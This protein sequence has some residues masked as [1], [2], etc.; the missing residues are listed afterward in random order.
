MAT[1]LL[2][3]ADLL[4]RDWMQD[5]LADAGYVVVALGD[6][7]AALAAVRAAPPD[8]AIIHTEPREN[9]GARLLPHLPQEFPGLRVIAVSSSP[10]HVAH[11]RELGA[12]QGLVKPFQPAEL[13][14]LVR[15]ELGQED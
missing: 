6:A 9:E 1:I 11:A 3:G 12:H 7:A 8:L 15:H 2:V 10:E 14:G 4:V 13:L 5:F